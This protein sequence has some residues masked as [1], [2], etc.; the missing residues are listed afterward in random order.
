MH[1]MI[2]LSLAACQLQDRVSS[3]G[4]AGHHCGHGLGVARL[5]GVV[6]SS[7]GQRTHEIGVRMRLDRSAVLFI[8]LSCSKRDS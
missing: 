8:G 5:Y 4:S 2:D 3:S 7:V 1:R 6:S